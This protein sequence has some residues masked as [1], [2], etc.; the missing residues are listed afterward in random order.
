MNECTCDDL[1]ATAGEYVVAVFPGEHDERTCA[2][3]FLTEDGEHLANS[4]HDPD[5]IDAI[6]ARLTHIAAEIREHRDTA[7]DPA[8]N[9]AFDN[10]IRGVNWGADD[11][12]PER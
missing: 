9:S 1:H 3:G 5:L 11:A 7:D 10:I 4:V 2:A 12:P 6:A 8:V